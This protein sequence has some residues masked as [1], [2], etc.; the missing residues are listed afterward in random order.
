MEDDI[1]ELSVDK[2]VLL[3]PTSFENQVRT[4]RRMINIICE[5]EF[6]G[7]SE[8]MKTLFKYL[9]EIFKNPKTRFGNSTNFLLQVLKKT[10]DYI[11]RLE[12][13]ENEKHPEFFNS[14]KILKSELLRHTHE[15]PEG[16]LDMEF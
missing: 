13:N 5:N 8:H 4:I 3:H 2:C 1:L 9:F 12:T 14:L 7:D 16:V 15:G 11:E 10:N 6:Q